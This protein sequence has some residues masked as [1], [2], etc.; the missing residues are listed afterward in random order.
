MD[1]KDY[2]EKKADG[3]IELITAGGGYALASK[4]WNPEN[5]DL[6]EPE[7]VAVDVEALHKKKIELQ[8]EIEQIDQLLSDIKKI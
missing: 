6:I 8:T 3:R 7:I 5:G 1:Y 4:R 2:A